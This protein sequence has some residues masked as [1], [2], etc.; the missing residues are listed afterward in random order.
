M[1]KTVRQ[2]N[3]VTYSNNPAYGNLFLHDGVKMN[4]YFH[5]VKNA[6]KR[7]MFS[8]PTYLKTCLWTELYCKVYEVIY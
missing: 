8:Y 7:S 1:S 5:R 6:K 3:Q 4:R 2:P